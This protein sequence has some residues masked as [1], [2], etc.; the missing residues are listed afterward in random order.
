M[1]PSLLLALAAAPDAAA[2][3]WMISH[4]YTA[5]AGCHIDP[6][7]GGAL[8]AYG[9]S[10]GQL[11]LSPNGAESGG[12]PGKKKEFLFGLVKLPKG[13]TLQADLRGMAYPKPTEQA[14][15][16]LQ[17]DAQAL[18]MQSDLRA[19][20][21]VGKVVAYASAGVVS[22]G[23]QAAQLTSTADG[24]W[25]AVSRE[26]WAGYAPMK[27]LLVRAG[28]M[29]L[30]FGLRVEEHTSYV[31]SST[32][33][34]LN[35]DQQAGVAVS[36]GTRRYRAE[37]MGI[38]GNPQVAPADYREQGYSAM[39]AWSPVKTLE[40]GASSLVTKA[41]ADIGTLAP[42]TRQAHGVFGRYGGVPHTA[43]MAEGDLL[44]SDDDGV[45]TT[46]ATAMVLADF[47][48]TPGLHL[49]GIEQWCDTDLDD[50]TTGATT[51]WLSAIWFFAPRMDLRVDAL[52]GTLRCG[53]AADKQMMALGQF[54]VYL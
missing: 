1:L 50:S 28:R 15:G 47:E 34:N 49:R 46:G 23:A 18:L 52:N 48:A 6:S 24:R 14:D 31:R 41:D 5:C 21:N 53:D 20:V 2:Y 30:P 27:G 45:S 4:G 54:H 3:P 42:R 19:G 44:L 22:E 36:Y 51:E 8:T 38:A 25:N 40:V 26:Y 11:L 17:W 33:T 32:R 37:L 39:A 10:T 13:L 16:S 12:E 7:G 29:A 43:L 35:A 9:R